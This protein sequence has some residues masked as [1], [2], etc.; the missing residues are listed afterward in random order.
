MS[1]DDEVCRYSYISDEQFTLALHY[2]HSKYVSAELG[3]VERQRFRMEV[4]QNIATYGFYLTV[5]QPINMSLHEL[6]FMGDLE[7]LGWAGEA[8]DVT[9]SMDVDAEND[10]FVM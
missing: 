8:P 4:R 1:T 5:T 9:G 2:F 3:N 6:D 7:R 10:D